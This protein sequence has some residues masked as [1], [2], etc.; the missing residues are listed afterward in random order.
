M[1]TVLTGAAHSQ[2]VT[3]RRSVKM[4]PRLLNVN[5]L[6]LSDTNFGA[7]DLDSQADVTP[8]SR[9]LVAVNRLYPMRENGDGTAYFDT[10]RLMATQSTVAAVAERFVN[11]NPSQPIDKTLFGIIGVGMTYQEVNMPGQVRGIWETNLTS[12]VMAISYGGGGNTNILATFTNV[13][14]DGTNVRLASYDRITHQTTAFSGDVVQQTG[15][16]IGTFL[17][18][19]YGADEILYLL[20]FTNRRILKFSTGANGATR[21]AFLGTFNLDPTKPANN[22]M[23]MDPAGNIYIGDGDGGFNIYDSNG[24]WKQGFDGTYQNDPDA[25]SNIGFKPNLNYYAS[26]LNDGNGTLDVRDGTGYRQYTIT[27][28]DQTPAIAISSEPQSQTICQSSATN[29]SVIANGT[30]LTYQWRK[31]GVNLTD[32]GTISGATTANLNISSTVLADAGYYDVL[33]RKTGVIVTSQAAIISVTPAPVITTQPVA[34]SIRLGENAT[35]TAVANNSPNVQWQVSSDGGT[36]FSDIDGATSE[37]LIIPAVTTSQI[38]NHYRA[39]FASLC[40]N[41]VIS[42]AATL[43]L[44]QTISFDNPGGKTFGD[45]AFDLGGT[46]SSGLDI[47]YT[48]VFGPATVTGGM[49]TLTNSGIVSVKA[50]Q[51]GN[52]YYTA[53]P[54]VTQT[55]LV[56]RSGNPQASYTVDTISDDITLN[57]CTSAPNDCS[58]RAAVFAANLLDD[59]ETINF[60]PSLAGQTIILNSNNA[61]FNGQL[62]I[63][64]NGKLTINGLGSNQLKISGNNTSRVFFVE[65]NAIADINDLTITNGKGY[66][67]YDNGYGG[68]VYNLESALTLTNVT[69]S[70]SSAPQGGGIYNNDGTLVLIR[71]TV[72][73]NST[74]GG[75]RGG[76]IISVGGTLTL[77]ASTVSGNSTLDTIDR[78]GEGGGLVLLYGNVTITNSTVSGNRSLNNLN[79][80]FGGGFYIGG[81]TVTLSNSTISG[82]MASGGGGIYVAN[83]GSATIRL[84][85]MT[86]TDNRN[87]G[88]SVGYQYCGGIYNA[89]SS[90]AIYVSNSIIARNGFAALRWF[91][92]KG[93]FISE[94]YN[95]I[96]NIFTDPSNPEYA[97]GFGATGDKFGVNYDALDARL[98]PLDFYGGVTKTH[99][100]A[101]GSPAIDAGNS[102]LPTDQRGFTRPFDNPSVVNAA[103]GNGADIGAVE[104]QSNIVQVSLPIGAVGTVGG[105]VTI[106]VTISRTSEGSPIESFDFSVFYNP[107]VLQPAASIGSSSGTLSANCSTIPNSPVSGRVTVSGVCAQAVTNG[108]G[109]LYNLTFNIIGAVNQTSSLSF[110]NPANNTNT[111]QFNGT[112]TAA[113]SSGQFTV[114]A[115]T[116]ANASVSGRVLTP[117]GRGLINAVVIMTDVGGT[118]RTAITGSFGYFRFDDV[119]AGQTH[120]VSVRSKSYS[121]APQIITVMEDLTELNF[122]AR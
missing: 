3:Y 91:D 114:L 68:A 75:G 109:A 42:N 121:F 59:D 122:T 103:G 95:L 22:S 50:S 74:S 24:Q 79:G 69:V 14:I 85:N 53:A 38:G 118:T 40:G 115:P 1:L 78:A 34:Q 17:Q 98:L 80:G 13:N 111:F 72:S 9:F 41:P 64:D 89:T 30:N 90:A 55:F 108:S 65:E 113:T 49:L 76:G 7:T 52:N 61:S 94:G 97:T 20:D 36:S 2:T 25:I 48:V 11:P 10:Q 117:D 6:P 93:N 88:S 58:L 35:F 67:G 84:N 5:F 82:N 29:L 57:A 56:R 37:M 73:N 119:E 43:K 23:T 120:I 60:D 47:S 19:V 62:N 8:Y 27:A 66:G 16:S 18:M 107:D 105:S 86:V 87:R 32:G 28:P 116:A 70:N 39:V 110:T 54:D 46:A 4:P 83:F 100:L 92:V 31:N 21:G 96:G 106:P 112:P 26:G 44:S 45:P 12:S 101:V 99:A 51:S 63:A 33:I 104:M 81:G 15:K 77:T 102:N 71:S